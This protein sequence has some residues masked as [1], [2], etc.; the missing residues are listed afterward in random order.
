MPIPFGQ[1]LGPYRIADLLGQGAMGQVYRAHDPRLGRD[2]AIKF[3][4]EAFAAE[5]ERLRRFEQEAKVIAQLN[6]PNIVQIFDTGVWEGLPYLVMELVEGQ[7]LRAWMAGGVPARK[8]AAMARQIAE[9]LAA[10]HDAGIVHRDLKPEN[11]LVGRD[12][13][14]RILDFGLAKLFFHGPGAGSSM[15]TAGLD[16]Q[17]E[18]GRIVGTV[19]YMAPEQLIDGR[20][21][22]R[23]DLFALGVTLWEML[24]GERPFQGSSVIDTMHAILRK[25]L[26]DLPAERNVPPTLERILKRCLEKEPSNR[27][28][29]ARDLAFALLNLEGSSLDTRSQALTLPAPARGRWSRVA[30]A[31]PLLALMIV[32]V[33]GLLGGRSLF[34]PRDYRL[35][36][37]L[38]YPMVVTSAR[39]M[40]DGKALVFSVAKPDGGEELYLQNPGEPAPRALMVKDAEVLAV[41]PTGAIALSWKRGDHAVLALLTAPGTAPRVLNEEAP[42]TA[43]WDAEGKELIGTYQT[44]EGQKTQAFVYRGKPLYRVPWGRG[45]AGLTLSRDGSGFSFIEGRGSQAFFM[46]VGL[47]GKVRSQTLL[48]NTEFRGFALA[49]D[50]FVV[51]DAK[52]NV[53]SELREPAMAV[54]KLFPFL[55]SGEILDGQRSGNLLLAGQMT[56][57]G[58]YENEG[59]RSKLWWRHPGA[60]EARLVGADD[61]GEMPV[62]TQGGTS[63]GMTQFGPSEDRCWMLHEGSDAYT[64]IGAGTLLALTEQGDWGIVR[65]NDK[66]AITLTLTPTGPGRSVAIPGR[67]VR[68]KAWFFEEGRRALIRALPSG[69]ADLKDISYILDTATGALQP[70]AFPAWGPVAQKGMG[71]APSDD[72]KTHGWRVVQLATGQ[73]LPLPG[74]A[75]NQTPIGWGA[76][77]QQVRVIVGQAPIGP[78]FDLPVQIAVV[79][80]DTG[81]VLSTQTLKG[82][83]TPQALAKSFQFSRDG[84]AFAFTESIP[85]RDPTMLYRLSVV[86]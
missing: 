62:L 55:G 27:F 32:G 80:L 4:S 58:T 33:A 42:S 21:D 30:W 68:A 11:V 49:E 73:S 2:V 14:P 16:G 83:G 37:L 74:A 40:P 13:R 9:G 60:S 48:A 8:A 70:L 15:S 22:G 77:D 57:S 78:W 20:L 46:I 76:S 72:P 34:R 29:N 39:F 71:F 86:R 12:G 5:A 18:P 25:D 24:T 10:A 85:H 23:T 65:G 43:C 28:Q 64:P 75:K 1:D 45:T 26:P 61:S 7:T 53:L 19:S 69:A 36:A 31:G 41:S 84:R 81:K 59:W 63:L 47:D 82:T 6:H 50:R 3:L 38:P 66:D 54:T 44:F 35:E 79:D 56:A 67:W 52:D 17:T 51:L